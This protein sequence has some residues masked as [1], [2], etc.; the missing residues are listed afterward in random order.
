MDEGRQVPRTA[1]VLQAVLASVF[2]LTGT[3][4]QIIAL[5]SMAMILTGM[6]TVGSLFVLRVRQPHAERPYRALGYP[7]LP[8]IYLV[9]SI[10]V[11][12]VMIFSALQSTNPGS[13]YPV[14]GLIIMLAAY[15]Y[16]R[17]RTSRPSPGSR[18]TSR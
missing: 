1:L 5:V 7:I 9:S 10:F 8:A 15:L 12:G 17:I 16:H 14:L 3:F 6:F 4:E 13:W 18:I 11:L 2:V